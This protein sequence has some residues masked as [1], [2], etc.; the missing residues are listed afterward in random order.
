MFAEVRV[1]QHFV[2]FLERLGPICDYYSVDQERRAEC[3]ET[4]GNQSA[5]CNVDMGPVTG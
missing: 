5:I 2:E 1:V 3:S 4:L